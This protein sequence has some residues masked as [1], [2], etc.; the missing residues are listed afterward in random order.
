MGTMRRDEGGLFQGPTHHHRSLQVLPWLVVVPL[1]KNL[2]FNLGGVRGR[3]PIWSLLNWGLPAK[4][5]KHTVGYE[6]RDIF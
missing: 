4:P 3:G 2:Q 1:G 6:C 5:V